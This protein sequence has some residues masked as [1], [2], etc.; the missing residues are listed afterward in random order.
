MLVEASRCNQGVTCAR[1]TRP[2]RTDVHPRH[3]SCAMNLFR[4]LFTARRQHRHYAHI[5][6]AGI[7]RAFKHCAQRPSGIEWVEVTEQRLSW[8]NQPLPASA[9]VAQRSARSTRGQLLTA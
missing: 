2:H 7:C 8:L 9:R 3:R 5:D 6:Q 4:S 1:Q